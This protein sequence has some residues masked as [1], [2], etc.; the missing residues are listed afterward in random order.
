MQGNRS[1]HGPEERSLAS[2]ELRRLIPAPPRFAGRRT[3]YRQLFASLFIGT[4]DCTVRMRILP[5]STSVVLQNHR[6][7]LAPHDLTPQHAASLM[8]HV[9]NS[10]QG[11]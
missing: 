4:G 6:M 10:L 1:T 2:S 7:L 3:Q 11:E 9:A 5:A 8:S